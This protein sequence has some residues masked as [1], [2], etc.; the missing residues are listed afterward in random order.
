MKKLPLLLMLLVTMTF[1]SFDHP[2]GWVKDGN[3]DH[4]E[5]TMVPDGHNGKNAVTIKSSSTTIKS[6]SASIWQNSLP[7]NFIGHRVKMTAFLKCQNVLD[8]AGLWFNVL[9]SPT[10]VLE[11]DEYFLTK[12]TDW[13]KFEI[14]LD[15]PK[16]TSNLNYGAFLSGTGQL[17]FSDIH[18]EIVDKSIASTSKKSE[19]YVPLDGEPIDAKK[20]LLAT[21]DEPTNL[22]FVATVKAD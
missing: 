8:T 12:T 4:Y 19:Q 18:F 16:G 6:H 5:I 11:T 22:D 15:I 9:N 13:K 3:V 2:R 20:M 7:T 10:Q 14:V 17:W 21:Q 1:L